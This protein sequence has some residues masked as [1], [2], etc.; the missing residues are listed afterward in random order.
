MGV[1]QVFQSLLLD[2]SAVEEDQD[3]YCASERDAM[4]WSVFAGR[5]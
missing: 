5:Q 3:D 1:V 2:V 4:L